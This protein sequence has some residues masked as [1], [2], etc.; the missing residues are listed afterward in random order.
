MKRLGIALCITELDVGGAERCLVELATRLDRERFAPVV[1]ALGFPPEGDA[2]CLTA[3]Q[4]VG[5]DVHFLGATRSRQ[6]FAVLNRLKTLLRKQ[7]PD[8]VQSFLFHANLAGRIAARRAGVPR[9]VS[10]IR[11]AERRSRWPLWADR[12]TDRLV[13]R[14]VCVSRA[15]AQF[16]RDVTGL[17]PEKLVVIP[18][19]I[20]ASLYPATQPADLTAVGI[21]PGRRL[22]T[23]V[24]RLEMQKGVQWLVETAPT[25]LGQLPDCDL[26]LVGK[27]PER[28]HLRRMSADRGIA[29]R[30]HFAG[31]RSDVPA[32][33]ARSDLL[34]LPSAWEGMPNV[35]LEAMASGLPVVASN[36]EGVAELLGPDADAQTVAHGDTPGYSS[37]VVGIMTDPALAGAL[38]AKNRL[39]AEAE[40]SLERMVSAYEDLW[41]SLVEGP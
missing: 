22:V 27:G 30:V 8:V 19:G 3:L 18:N 16:S 41:E 13:D 14:H 28:E 7:S 38:G 40:F 33:L 31:W 15:V 26:L 20:D 34:V 17:P 32:I 10:G 39:R 24:G 9:A 29:D 2:S 21:P 6:V 35:V 4:T 1:Y 37:K 11:V 23:Y 5:I 36:V 12:L 25:W